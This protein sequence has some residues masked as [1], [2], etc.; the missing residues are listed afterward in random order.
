[1]QNQEIVPQEAKSGVPVRKIWLDLSEPLR[2]CLLKSSAF[3]IADNPGLMDEARSHLPALRQAATIPAGAAGIRTII[4]KRF[5]L[6]PQPERGEGEWAAWWADYVDALS[7][8]SP[9]ALEAG[10]KAWVGKPDSAFLPKPGELRRLAQQT[11]NALALAIGTIERAINRA[12]QATISYE[13][14][15]DPEARTALAASVKAVAEGWRQEAIARRPVLPPVH[16]ELAEGF[17][18]TPQMIELATRQGHISQEAT[19]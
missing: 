11:P 2:D 6:Y 9:S 19:R 15:V 13:P 5:A 14:P 17:A 16:G 1:M 18:L 10:M 7:D 12:D 8:I 3:D 4:G